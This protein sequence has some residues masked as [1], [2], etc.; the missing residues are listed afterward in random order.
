VRVLSCAV[1]CAKK[2]CGNYLFGKNH[3]LGASVGDEDVVIETSAV[4]ELS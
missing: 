3:T 2:W 1:R 4:G